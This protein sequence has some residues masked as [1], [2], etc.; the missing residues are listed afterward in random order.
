MWDGFNRNK[1]WG[2]PKHKKSAELLITNDIRYTTYNLPRNVSEVNF[3][4]LMS[5]EEGNYLTSVYD[6]INQSEYCR[7]LFEGPE[8]D[9][10]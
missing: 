4:A 5:S 6:E 3:D 1:L 8:V 10:N 9:L 7:E 2:S